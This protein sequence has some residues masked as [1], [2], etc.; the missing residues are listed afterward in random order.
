MDYRVN[1]GGCLRGQISVPGDK[2]ISHRVVML[3]AIADGVTE[4]EGLL[5]GADVLATIA[6]FQSMGVH[7]EGPDRGHLRIE[8]VGLRG[9]RAP[10]DIIDCGNSGDR[11]SVV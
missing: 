3:G 11:K 10:S 8:G 1:P 6:A 2:S 7:M 4:A 5:E 9:L